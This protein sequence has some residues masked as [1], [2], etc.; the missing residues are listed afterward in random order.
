MQG[1]G[2]QFGE[3]PT[4]GV[5]GQLRPHPVS[6]LGDEL[7]GRGSRVDS[8][9]QPREIFYEVLASCSPS[10]TGEEPEIVTQA[11]VV[12]QLAVGSTNHGVCHRR[13][14]GGGGIRRLMTS[15]H[16]RVL[17]KRPRRT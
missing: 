7:E 10:D 17:G 14:I 8:D 6:H 12:G 4:R 9:V 2:A 13:W 5:A 15:V 11:L 3:I 16:R 1:Q